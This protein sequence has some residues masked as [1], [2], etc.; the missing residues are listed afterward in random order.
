MLRLTLLLC[1]AMLLALIVWGEDR[2]QL[3]PGL[4]KAA[5]EAE[6]AALEPPAGATPEPPPPVLAAPPDVAPAPVAEETAEPE[7]YVE[8]ERETVV[9][10]EEPIFSLANVGNEAVPGEEDAPQPPE[11]VEEDVAAEGL[12]LD[13]QETEATPASAGGGVWYVTASSVN[14]RAEPSTEADILAKLGQGEAAVLVAEV[15]AEWAQII[16]QSDGLV[17]YVALRY[18]SQTAP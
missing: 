16:V 6:L 7:P 1:G 8:P 10:V 14:L 9:A 15:D 11:V 17:G 13:A 4:E 18:L 5:R 3:R 2:G 12:V